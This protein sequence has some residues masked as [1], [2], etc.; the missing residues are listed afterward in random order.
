[1]L[2]DS[3]CKLSCGYAQA[4]NNWWQKMTSLAASHWLSSKMFYCYLLL[5]YVFKNHFYFANVF[6]SKQR[7]RSSLQTLKISTRNNFEK[8]EQNN[9]FLWII[10]LK[11]YITLSIPHFQAFLH[12][13]QLSEIMVI[14][15][16]ISV[17]YFELVKQRLGMWVGHNIDNKVM[18]RLQTFLRYKYYY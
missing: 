14:K 18:Q 8:K 16:Q 13:R 6:Y 10:Y 2:R 15:P 1:M 11:N 7:C 5:F 17:L 12:S 4:E 3:G 9:I